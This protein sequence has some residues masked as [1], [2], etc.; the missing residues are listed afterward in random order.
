MQIGDFH[1]EVLINGQALPEYKSTVY[2]WSISRS[3]SSSP[4]TYQGPYLPYPVNKYPNK[5]NQTSYG[6]PGTITACFFKGIIVDESALIK[7][8]FESQAS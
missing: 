3:S 5:Q 8:E 4:T 7:P 1:L 6:R 2:R